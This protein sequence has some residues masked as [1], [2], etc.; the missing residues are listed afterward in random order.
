MGTN[1]IM[2][3]PVTYYIMGRNRHLHFEREVIEHYMRYS[4]NECPITGRKIW[5]LE[6][7]YELKEDIE[8]FKNRKCLHSGVEAD[9]IAYYSNKGRFNITK[10]QNVLRY[11]KIRDMN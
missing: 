10:K 3:D 1:E 9:L 2:S 11:C 6:T 4:N 7:D 8:E 5:Y